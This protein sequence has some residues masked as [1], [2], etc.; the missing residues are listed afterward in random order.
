MLQTQASREAKSAGLSFVRTWRHCEAMQCFVI[1]ASLLATNTGNLFVEFL[2]LKSTSVE[3][4]QNVAGQLIT[5]SF[6][7]TNS[8]NFTDS[9]AAVS[10]SLE[11]HTVLIG[12]V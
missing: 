9:T 12:K 2:R 7:R 6:L 3:T 5:S 4:V 1:T 8:S 10:S 11:I